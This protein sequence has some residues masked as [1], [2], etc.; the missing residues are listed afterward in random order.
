MKRGFIVGSLI[1]TFLASTPV[2]AQHTH[3][4]PHSSTHYDAVRH[5]NHFHNVPHTTTHYDQV[6]HNGPD[7]VPHTSTH[8]D[9]YY[10][11]GHIDSV[12]HT[13]THLHPTYPNTYGVGGGYY[14]P[15]Q[16]GYPSPLVQPNN[17]L[18]NQGVITT[19]PP[20][21][22]V[23]NKIPVNGNRVVPR[24][25]P[26]GKSIV[27]SNPKDNGGTVSYTVNTYSYTIR[28]GESQTLALDRDWVIKFDNGLGKQITYR[29]GEGRYEFAVSPES[30]W[31]VARRPEITS[32]PDAPIIANEPPP[33]TANFINQ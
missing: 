23:A 15:Q 11:N 31:D 17:M 13:T 3:S 28:P 21:T 18:P 32:R 8:Y 6:Y 20:S 25:R 1:A 9:Q 26:D 12:P 27:L 2:S 30:G 19:P 4:V 33:S 5:G 7:Y 29:L 10:H 16:F 14:Q 24:N 22:I